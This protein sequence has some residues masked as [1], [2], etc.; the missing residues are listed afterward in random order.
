MNYCKK[1]GSKI[2]SQLSNISKFEIVFNNYNNCF[3]MNEIDEQ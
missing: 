2:Y 1:I 3:Q